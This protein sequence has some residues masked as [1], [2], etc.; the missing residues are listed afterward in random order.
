MLDTVPYL[1][2]IA[3]EPE[4]FYQSEVRECRITGKKEQAVEPDS[5]RKLF[6]FFGTALITPNDRRPKDSA[7]AVQ[8]N[9]SMHL[10]RQPNARYLRSRYDFTFEN[11]LNGGLAR[12]PPIGR[13]LF[14]P[15]GLIRRERLM[16][17]CGRSQKLPAV[18][19]W[20]RP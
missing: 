19:N 12:L 15:G 5:L 8:G 20:Q 3:A 7:F 2:L 16:S 1:R 14:R 4:K 18:P 11:R 13:I 6:G 17:G 10:P 9:R